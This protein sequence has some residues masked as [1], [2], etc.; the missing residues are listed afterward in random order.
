MYAITAAKFTAERTAT[1]C[2]KQTGILP[3][4][5]AREAY[6]RTTASRLAQSFGMLSTSFIG[7]QKL[8]PARNTQIAMAQ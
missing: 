7:V 3:S 1:I 8:P 4:A 6:S 5:D 2:N